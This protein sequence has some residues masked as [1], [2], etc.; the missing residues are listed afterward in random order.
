M[1]VEEGCYSGTAVHRPHNNFKYGIEESKES[2][3]SA[4]VVNGSSGSCY[5]S[6]AGSFFLSTTDSEI[7]HSIT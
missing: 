2:T 4:D 6:T 1:I 7:A 5:A 3:A